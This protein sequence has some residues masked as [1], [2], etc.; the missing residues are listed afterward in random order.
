VKSP[1]PDP[2][3]R[4]AGTPTPQLSLGPEGSG[5]LIYHDSGKSKSKYLDPTFSQSAIKL[6]IPAAISPVR[7]L[8]AALVF[9]F[10]SNLVPTG[11]KVVEYPGLGSV[12]ATVAASKAAP[13]TG[14]SGA[15]P[16][17]G[18][19]ELTVELETAAAASSA[20]EYAIDLRLLYE[21]GFIPVRVT[22]IY[23]PP[24]T[25]TEIAKPTSTPMPARFVT[26]G[27]PFAPACG[28]P[29]LI[30]DN[31]LNGPT[32]RFDGNHGHFDIWPSDCSPD[33][34]SGE[35]IA[36]VSGKIQKR[37]NSYAIILPQNTYLANME[38]AL[39]FMGVHNPRLSSVRNLSID[40]GHLR[41]LAS[42]KHGDYVEK[43]QPIGD[44]T[45]SPYP[46]PKLAYQVNLSYGS[47]SYMAS[48]TLFTNDVNFPISFAIPDDPAYKTIYPN[49]EG[50]W[51]FDPRIPT[52]M[53]AAWTP[54]YCYPEPLAYP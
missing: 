13:G 19:Y 7:G 37:A 40:L 15:A 24:P 25:P 45:T 48:P 54:Y 43:G 53:G 32:G 28:R 49:S 47:V 39:S 8:K 50:P 52:I 20:S 1:T 9:F 4:P 33:T 42:L 36:P 21:N 3:R 14:D 29:L 16:E 18:K 10:E 34:A 44:L 2:T 22:G 35:V 51:V 46:S 5:L 23:P 38:F 30:C 31:S 6:D 17:Y 26:L 11:V 27:P 41:L 12:S